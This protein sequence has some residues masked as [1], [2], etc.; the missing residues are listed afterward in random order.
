MKLILGD[1]DI[2][3]SIPYLITR[4]TL[5][6]IREDDRNKVPANKRIDNAIA[7]IQD[8]D[9]YKALNPIEQDIINRKN[10]KLLLTNG[11]KNEQ[12]KKTYIKMEFT[13]TL[14]FIKVALLLVIVLLLSLNYYKGGSVSKYELYNGG[15]V[16]MNKVTGEVY[17]YSD[18]E[19]NYKKMKILE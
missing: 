18:S 14:E 1:N 2:E 19:N 9:W 17:Y 8:I 10:I 15:R 6:Q 7:L 4:Q 11:L 5:D 12:V 3:W 13:R 16:R